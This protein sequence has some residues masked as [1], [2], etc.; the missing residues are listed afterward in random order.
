MAAG[1]TY[2]PIATQTLT[3]TVATITFSSIPSTY[4]DLVLIINASAN[5]S[6]AMNYQFN[7]DTTSTNYSLTGLEGLGSSAGSYRANSN[8]L[9]GANS[10]NPNAIIWNIQ[11]YSNTTTFK[12]SIVRSN[13]PNSDVTA[14]VTLWRNTAA[15][16]QIVIG[17]L[18]G[19]QYTI[20]STFTLYGLAAA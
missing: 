4:T 8:T 7:G 15:I 3:G 16:N 6:N 1:S 9:A 19:A 20:G 13:L 11:N 10:T 12:T 2:T 5:A 17:M 14:R 18:G